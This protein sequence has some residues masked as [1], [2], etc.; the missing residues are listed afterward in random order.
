MSTSGKQTGIKAAFSLHPLQFLLAGV[1]NP[2]PCVPFPLARGR[3]GDWKEGLAPL[4]N[5]LLLCP[6]ESQ[7]EA[8]PLLLKIF[9]LSLGERGIKGVRFLVIGR[10]SP[11]LKAKIEAFQN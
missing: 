2:I 6:E 8:E 9:P 4:L 3:G 7:R 1:F 10:K 5:A 11:K